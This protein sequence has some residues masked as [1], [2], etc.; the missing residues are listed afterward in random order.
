MYRYIVCN[1][2]Y[3]FSSDLML[4]LSANMYICILYIVTDFYIQIQYYILKDVKCK[5]GKCKR[6]VV[7]KL[8]FPYNIA[9]QMLYYIYLFILYTSYTFGLDA[10]ICI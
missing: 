3:R 7:K 2:V 5:I 9:F 6:S 10:D 1:Y 4:S 8:S